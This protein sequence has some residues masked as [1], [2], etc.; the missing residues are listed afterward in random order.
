VVEE[1]ASRFIDQLARQSATVETPEQL[2]ELLRALRRRHARERRAGELT[3]R[4]LAER[5]GWSQTSIAEYFT[6]RTVPPVDRFDALLAVLEARPAERGALATARD[7]V[8]EQRHRHAAATGQPSRRTGLGDR[9]RPPEVPR[10][11]PPAVRHFSARRATLAELTGLTAITGMAGVGKSALA[12]HWA[13]MVADQF[14]DGQLYVNLRG[15]D[16]SGQ[17][18]EPAEALRRFLDAL[19]VAAAR[20]PADVDAQAALYRSIVAGRRMLILLDNARDPAQVRPLLPG[21]QTCLVLVTSRS[22][23]AGLVAVD[24]AQ[25]VNV[26]PL[27]PHEAHDLLARRL[28][29]DRLATEPGAVADI[30]AHCA[31]LPLAL[32]IVAARAATH[33]GFGLADLA[34][35]M[36]DSRSRL[37]ALA[38][39]DEPHTDVRAVFFWSY[40]ALRPP[41]ARLFRLLALHPGA[42]FPVAAAASLAA[43][44]VRRASALMAELTTGGLLVESA[45]GRYVCHDLLRAYAAELVRTDPEPERRAAV[46]RVLDHYL[47]TANAADRLLNPGGDPCEPP[48]PAPGVTVV[49]PADPSAAMAWFVAEHPALVAA[50]DHGATGGYDR[51]AWQLAQAMA[52]FLE[53][54]QHWSDQ[55]AVQHAAVGAAA[56]QSDGRAEA[57]ARRALARA[58][59]E[60]GRD[61]DAYDQLTRALDGTVRAG[62][63]VGQAHTHHHLAY[64]WERRGRYAE[65]LDHTQQ[66]LPL[67]QAAGHR[68]GEARALNGLGW[69]HTLLGEHESAVLVCQQALVL[70]RELGNRLGQGATWDSIGYAHS[71]LGRYPLAIAC[72][73]RGLALIRDSGGGPYLE[74]QCLHHLGDA[75][76]AAEHSDAARSA[77]Q[78]ALDILDALDHPD[79]GAVRGKLA[80]TEAAAAVVS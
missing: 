54:G 67:Y 61:D 20:I 34:E 16:P 3:Y 63:P 65:A 51:H 23:L 33:R 47:H 40:R 31:G 24:G 50:V 58:Y 2:A 66:A 64:L 56:R 69:F 19:G 57:T 76:H 8:D 39:A 36:V 44:P 29:P 48:P 35:E 68:Y 13:H 18:V 72:H 22:Q 60:L 42:E 62:D 21:G 37:D 77:W 14:P 43:L 10:Q 30:V 27:N 46:G 7:R 49:E 38:V 70:L 74:A 15:F 25:P 9:D 1:S 59:I 6:A 41:A 12:V 52:T 11:L 32:A 5:T 4:Q 71:R 53:R 17:P 78:Q 79:A 75:H 73:R 45:P 55:A 80:A 28:G 26:D